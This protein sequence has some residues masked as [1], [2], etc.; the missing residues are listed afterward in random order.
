MATRA[1]IILLTATVCL[2]LSGRPQDAD[3]Y[4][5]RGLELSAEG[6]TDAALKA[7]QEA[8]RLRPEHAA[9]W[10]AIGVILATRGDYEGADNPF[11]K[12]CGLQPSLADA[13]LYHGRTLYLLNR[14]APA[15]E[16]LRL[17][18]RRDSQNGE[19]YRL[20]GLSLEALGDV[21]SATA[22]F[23]QAMRNP[24]RS[25]PDE[26]P[27]IDYGVFLFRQ[28]KA[29]EAIAPLDEV[30]KRQPN[31]GRAHLELGCVLLALDRLNEAAD[32]L[33]KAVALNPANT[34]AHL[35]LGKAYLRLGKTEA[36]EEQLRQGSR[37]VR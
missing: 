29:E 9:A 28:G 31:A 21:P 5:H 1:A 27:G 35:L 37:T 32:H 22:A 30:L 6:K 12:A 25:P 24:L 15:V 16:I 23:L 36:A 7:F 2:R 18:V 26:D 4:F 19:A 13:C 33:E 34:R 11:R 20:L 17:T 14:F 10:K 3:V 8:V